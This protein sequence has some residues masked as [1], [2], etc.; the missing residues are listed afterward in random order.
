MK[1]GLVPISAKP[2]HA[3]HHYL[4]ETASA[5]NDKVIV[6]ASTSDRKRKGEFP[7]CGDTMRAIW[8][9]EILKIMPENVEVVF[10]GS[11]VRKVYEIIGEACDDTSVL[12]TFTVYSDVVDTKMNYSAQNRKK[13]MEPLWSDNRVSFAAEVIP[14]SF[15]RG[16][17][18]PDIRAEDVRR[19]LKNQD[20]LSF[21]ACMPSGL[22][23]YSCWTRLLKSSN[24]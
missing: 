16:S 15:I 1:I 22:N 11:P 18:A 19:H 3:G 10:G 4:I 6:Y 13:Y 5:K 8:Q 12:D 20:F 23:S 17:G 7:I 21:S 2:Y 9:E 24:K 14:E